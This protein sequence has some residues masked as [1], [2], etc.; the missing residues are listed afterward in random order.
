[1]GLCFAV[2][3]GHQ[4]CVE[5]LLAAGA[6]PNIRCDSEYLEG[7]VEWGDDDDGTEQMIYAALYVANMARQPELA[8][9]IQRHGGTRLAGG[10]P[11]AAARRIKVSQG[12]R[13]GA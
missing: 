4:A 1:M 12:S 7:A 13:M 10:Q 3:E 6:D 11:K 9:L 5:A 2:R 8:E